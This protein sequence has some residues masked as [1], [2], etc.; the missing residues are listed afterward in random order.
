[1]WFRRV[2][3]CDS[4]KKNYISIQVFHMLQQFSV[5]LRTRKKSLLRENK[6][7]LTERKKDITVLVP[8]S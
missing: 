7:I 4:I 5:Y 6:N 8:P 3:L 1:M 2:P